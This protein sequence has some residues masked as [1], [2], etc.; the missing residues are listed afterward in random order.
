M[1]SSLPAANGRAA[2]FPEPEWLKRIDDWRQALERC[3]QKP[4]KKRVHAMR[5]STLRLH[6]PLEVW[7]RERA[8]E[9]AAGG[10][11]R[12]WIKQADKLRRLLSSVR[13]L[14]V[15]LDLMSTMQSQDAEGVA[16]QCR[17]GE[18]CLREL[19]KLEKRLKRERA[20]AKDDFVGA[21]EK[22]MRAFGAAGDSL[23]E[24]FDGPHVGK[25][26]DASAALR[27]TLK[28]LVQDAPGLGPETLHDFRK[29][30]KMARYL[31]EIV[32]RHEPI[33][34]RA[35]VLL[36]KIQSTVGEWHDW[37]TLADTAERLLKPGKKSE[38][39]SVIRTLSERSFENA[40]RETQDVAKELSALAGGPEAL[41]PARFGAQRAS[42]GSSDLRR[43][44]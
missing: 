30:A 31:A 27:E 7:L 1:N 5:V 3:T 41:V 11:A 37:D 29:R 16:A 35:A 43:L 18:S 2:V 26:I 23:R 17:A 14:D 12:K 9:D 25:A 19:G 38:L 21:I 4:G 33:A 6:A 40:L 13:D 20:S 15:L 42:A 39:F 10:A 28:G 22:K 32:E 24:A 34:K 44:A 36:K 8:V